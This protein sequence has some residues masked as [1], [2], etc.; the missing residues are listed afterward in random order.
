M[1][2]IN[3]NTDFNI[4]K[5]KWLAGLLYYYYGH[6]LYNI[7]VTTINM[8]SWETLFTCTAVASSP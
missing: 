4:F 3:V 2:H 1:N 7:T 6:I 5:K 8:S